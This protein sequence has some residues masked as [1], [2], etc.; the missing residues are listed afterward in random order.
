MKPILNQ[1]KTAA[2]KKSPPFG[3]VPSG[4]GGFSP[5]THNSSIFNRQFP[6]AEGCRD[7]AVPRSELRSAAVG[8][9]FLLKSAILNRQSAIPLRL[10]AHAGFSL[11]EVMVA[12]VLAVIVIITA[13]SQIVNILRYH[14]EFRIDAILLEDVSRVASDVQGRIEMCT[15]WVAS[16][17]GGW[18]GSFPIQVNGVAFETNRYTNVKNYQIVATNGAFIETLIR[19]PKEGLV[20]NTINH[21]IANEPGFRRVVTADYFNNLGPGIYRAVFSASGEWRWA[22]RMYTNTVTVPRMIVLYN[23]N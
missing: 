11:M 1:L 8:V 10:A 4:R 22:G 18:E 9:G 7:G 12:T 19:N 20:T 6:F 21:F 13:G 3:G 5:A 15:N 23:A 16:A 2:Q 17:S 14:N